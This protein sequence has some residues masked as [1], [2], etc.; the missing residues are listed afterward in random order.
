M[1]LSSKCAIP[2]SSSTSLLRPVFPHDQ[3]IQSRYSR[4]TTNR[5]LIPTSLKCSFP[6]LFLLI[7][8]P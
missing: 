8:P 5:F 7:R 6:I 3:T 1:S 2:I 4:N